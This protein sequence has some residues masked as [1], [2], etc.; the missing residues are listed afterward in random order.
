MLKPDSLRQALTAAIVD[1]AGVKVLEREPEKLA[2][3]IDKGR[4]AARA[5]GNKGFEWRYRLT[6]IL[7]DFA[8]NVDTVALAVILW[9]ATYQPE[10]L[11]NHDTGN[12]A[13]KFDADIL[14][15]GTIDLSLE[16][17]LN[18]AVDAVPRAGGGFDVVHRPEPVAAPP[19]DDVPEE[20]PLL[21]FY[22]H[23]ELILDFTPPAP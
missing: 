9:I 16:L 15:A 11:E 7:T 19:F 14:D 22:L 17:E 12:E 21:Q 18:E 23:D 3:F 20:T 8:G 5:G 2:I 6:A 4:I 10:L 13:V 1:D